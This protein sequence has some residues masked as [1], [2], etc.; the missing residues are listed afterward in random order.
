MSNFA[1]DIIRL[2]VGK[3]LDNDIQNTGIDFLNYNSLLFSFEHLPKREDNQLSGKVQVTSI[4]TLLQKEVRSS[5]LLI[6]NGIHKLA[7]PY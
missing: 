2:N 4:L 3:L 7:T 5:L 1:Y 6:F